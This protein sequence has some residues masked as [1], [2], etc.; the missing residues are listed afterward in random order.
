VREGEI[1]DRWVTSGHW[2]GRKG[3]AGRVFSL[4]VWL[5]LSLLGVW[6]HEYRASGMQR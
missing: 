6:C 4:L 3:G 1:T 5:S 2:M